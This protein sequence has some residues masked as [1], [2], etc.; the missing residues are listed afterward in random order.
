MAVGRSAALF[1]VSG[2]G[3]RAFAMPLALW[4]LLALHARAAGRRLGRQAR[5]KRGV[6]LA[7][8]AVLALLLLVGRV[9]IA[10][11]WMPP[12]DPT[13]VRTYGPVAILGICLMNVLSSTGE[14]A[15]TFSPGEVDFLFP[16]P[17]TRRQLLAYK[18]IRTAI[19]AVP[20]ALLFGALVSRFGGFYLGRVA[21]AWLTF[22][23]VQMLAMIV[24]LVKATVGER[25][26]SRGRRWL[27]L[28][29]LAAVAL[30]CAWM[31]RRHHGASPSDVGEQL[32]ASRAGQVILAPFGVFARALTA[33]RIVPDALRWDAV[34]LAMDLGLVAVVFLLDANYLE[35]AATASGK[36][37]ARLARLRQA[38][39]AGMASPGSAKL[40]LPMLPWLGGVGPVAWRQ[41]TGVARTSR[42]LLTMLA[43][44]AIVMGVIVARAGGGDATVPSLIGLSVWANLFLTSMLR[45]DFRGDLDHLD[46]LRSLPLRPWAVAAAELVAP[47][48]ALSAVQALLLTAATVSGRLP[49]GTV[50]MA[51]VF[52]VPFNAV[53]VGSEN[54]LFLLFPF[55][56]AAAVAGDMGMV[57]R[58]TVVFAARLL[59]LAA[60]AIA[61]G[62]VGVLA[63]L[64]AGRSI[65]IAAAAAWVPLAGA[66]V[67]VVAL[68]AAAY[69][70]FD[71]SVDT[72]S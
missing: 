43:I 50:L 47:T 30:A 22:Q 12:A 32:R 33:D 49:A 62:G 36:R 64:V 17:F 68:M 55:R 69:A 6:A 7:L 19:T 15:V 18:L 72:P 3:F 65:W 25:A 40:R 5:G 34:A 57:G 44:V 8:V 29:V 56:P 27:L 51:L 45:F 71:P 4:T 13:G 67:G 58:Q 46:L 61:V 63:F 14:R 53:L 48:V 41:L 1:R 39:L 24:A 2:F 54:L 70:R 59:I 23:F 16:G 11:R 38:G 10:N 21:A 35:A 52:V 66:V 31:I 60:V 37:Y 28:G 26:F 20:S 9:V 42:G